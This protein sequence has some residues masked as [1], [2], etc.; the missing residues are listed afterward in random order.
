MKRFRAEQKLERR[1][2]KLEVKAT[3]D[4]EM[5]ENKENYLH[6][7]DTKEDSLHPRF[8][9]DP[10]DAAEAYEN[11]LFDRMQ[12]HDRDAADLLQ[13]F[14]SS[15]RVIPSWND[16]EERVNPALIRSRTE[17][18]WEGLRRVYFGQ[19]ESVPLQ[20]VEEQSHEEVMANLRAEIASV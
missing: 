15:L 3:W 12:R 2:V 17:G 9:V 20:P 10:E 19:K 5:A 4:A 7:D 13:D 6:E 8:P 1:R 18:L 14:R 11:Y 16:E